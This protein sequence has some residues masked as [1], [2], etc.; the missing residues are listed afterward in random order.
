MSRLGN[1]IVDILKLLRVKHYIKNFLIFFP[2]IFSQK[3]F[4]HQL[5][6]V[7]GGFGLFCLAASM[8]YVINDIKDVDRDRL[9]TTKRERPLASGRIS[10]RTA[11]VLL[12]AMG[13]LL[14]GGNYLLCGKNGLSWL[15]LVSYIIINIGYS[16]GFK[17]IALL[18]IAILAIG[19]IL[20]LYYGAVIIGVEVSSW[21][22]LTVLSLAFYLGLG[23]RRN[24]IL[25]QKVSGTR[26]VLNVYTHNFL[27][28]NMY[29]CLTMAVIFY[30]L[31]SMQMAN[32][33]GKRLLLFTIPLMMLLCMRY[34]LIIEQESDGDPVEVVFRDKTLVFMALLYAVM[35]GLILYCSIF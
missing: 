22:Y 12:A 2:L 35:T 16:C 19:Y 24:E 20:R 26:K 6:T 7:F 25:R 17:N 28:K 14:L 1:R 4:T 29:V 23:K 32:E 30:S 33:Y 11:Y 31:W 21:L 5:W 8:I 13:V 18:D 34:S 27:D 3:L 15:T 10:M 9:H